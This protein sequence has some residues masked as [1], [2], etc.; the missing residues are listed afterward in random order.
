MKDPVAEVCGIVYNTFNDDNGGN[1]RHWSHEV[2]G[3]IVKN[4]SNNTHVFHAMLGYVLILIPNRYSMGAYVNIP[5]H[6]SEKQR[7]TMFERGLHV[8]DYATA[9]KKSS[10]WSENGICNMQTCGDFDVGRLCYNDDKECVAFLLTGT[11]VQFHTVHFTTE[12]TAPLGKHQ[13][14]WD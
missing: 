3:K 10:E 12:G 11:A 7:D 13:E 5:D 9:K 14:D 8:V 2:D 6:I 1:Y 4:L